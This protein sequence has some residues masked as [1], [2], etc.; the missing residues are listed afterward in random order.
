MNQWNATTRYVMP[1]GE[2]A[3]KHHN[4]EARRWNGLI[5]GRIDSPEAWQAVSKFSPK[6]KE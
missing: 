4:M 5:Q 1:K 6:V 2:V 3:I